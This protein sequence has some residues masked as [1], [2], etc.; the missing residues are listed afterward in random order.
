[1][2]TY[3]CITM[4]IVCFIIL[5]YKNKDKRQNK[6]LFENKKKI[7]IIGNSPK[8]LEYERGKE[9]D[10]FDKI[11]RFN[12]FEIKNFEKHT[13]TKTDIWFI[14]GV[15]IRKKMKRMMEKLN[16]VKCDKIYAETNTWDTKKRL[17]SFN[18]EME[19][20]K[21]L[22]FMDVN[23]FKDTQKIYNPKGGFNPHSSLGVRGIYLIAEKYPDY[24][25]Y[26]YGFDNFS[27]KKTHY[28][29]NKISDKKIHNVDRE[30]NFM[31]Y[32][33]DEYNIKRF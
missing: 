24:D 23:I 20:I 25:I 1:M 5:K 18:P 19:N 17:L 6:E 9:I 33:I 11:V 15:S 16:E 32:L 4:I 10:K 27:S 29:D 8:I 31:N 22:E 14:N 28:M 26:I 7:I 2:K 21:N 3:I 30:R 13:G 12:T